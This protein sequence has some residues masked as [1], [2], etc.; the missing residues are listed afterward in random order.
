MDP[1]KHFIQ[2][3]CIY[4]SV[5]DKNIIYTLLA[6]CKTFYNSKDLQNLWHAYKKSLYN[7]YV[8]MPYTYK[9]ILFNN[10]LEIFGRFDRSTIELSIYNRL[11][12]TASIDE[13][14]N[15]KYKLPKMFEALDYSSKLFIFTKSHMEQYTIAASI[16][17][18]ILS[19][20]CISIKK[21]KNFIYPA[22]SKLTYCSKWFPDLYH[23]PQLK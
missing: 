5:E 17:G 3:F 9:I 16:S 15:V 21:V 22:D 12:S 13:Q 6:T 20:K 19:C 23:L 2:I 7:A 4:L 11:I 18:R 14:F 10:N 8:C 1:V